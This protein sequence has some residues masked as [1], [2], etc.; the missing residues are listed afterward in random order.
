[1][2]EFPI[3]KKTHR[4]RPRNYYNRKKRIDNHHGTPMCRSQT[5]CVPRNAEMRGN[6]RKKENRP[7]RAIWRQGWNGETRCEVRQLSGIFDGSKIKQEKESGRKRPTTR[8]TAGG[9]ADRTR[10]FSIFALFL[11]WY[12][13][14]GEGANLGGVNCQKCRKTRKIVGAVIGAVTEKENLLWQ[15]ITKSNFP[16]G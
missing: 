6:T 10:F 2:S 9:N 4:A 13:F 12:H 11:K 16:S 3:K 8:F 5:A 7:F 1:M 14:R 15:P